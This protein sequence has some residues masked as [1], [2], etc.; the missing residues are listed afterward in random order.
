MSESYL[1]KGLS[2]GNTIACHDGE[3][4]NV[5]D[6]DTRTVSEAARQRVESRQ[7]KNGRHP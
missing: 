5:F 4:S 7:Y 2:H 1:C 3:Y 6:S